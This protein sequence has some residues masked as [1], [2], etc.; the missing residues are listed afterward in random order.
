M[1]IRL[2]LIVALAALSGACGS[3]ASPATRATDMIIWRTV[4]SW[5]GQGNA[6]T[7]SFIG[8]TASFRVDWQT[9]NEQPSGAGA[10]RLAL[11]SAVSGREL[12]VAVDEHG[13]GEGTSYMTEDPR[14]FHVVVES[15]N[16]DW[17]FTVQ[18]AFAGAVS[19]PS[20][21]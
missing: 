11:H 8:D 16:L 2:V 17:S 20:R 10:F 4:G 6:Q 15:A 18:E 13:I 7:E 19:T 3:Q 5:S 1:A 14:P 12:L 9:K 21:R